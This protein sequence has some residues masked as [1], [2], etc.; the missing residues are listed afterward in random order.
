MA[1]ASTNVSITALVIVSQKLQV[2]TLV[3]KSSSACNKYGGIRLTK[4]FNVTIMTY[5]LDNT[6][7]YDILEP[8]NQWNQHGIIDGYKSQVAC[9]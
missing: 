3:P 9:C 4:N 1:V 5:N 6:M 7:I 8:I 2:T